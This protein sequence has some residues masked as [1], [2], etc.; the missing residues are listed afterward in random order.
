MGGYRFLRGIAYGRNDAKILCNS[1]DIY[2]TLVLKFL[3]PVRTP[4][5]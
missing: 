4:Y 2:R 5:D 3:F 1:L